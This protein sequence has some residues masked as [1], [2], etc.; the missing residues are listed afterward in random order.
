MNSRRGSTRSPINRL[1]ISLASSVGHLD[2]QQCARVGIQRGLP[3]LVSVHFAKTF[4][5]LDREAPSPV[6]HHRIDQVY[7]ASDHG[8]PVAPGIGRSARKDLR[9]LLGSLR[10]ASCISCMQ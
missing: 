4:V 2:L 7:W 5:A 6:V 3:K 10:E 9:E 1:N 8:R